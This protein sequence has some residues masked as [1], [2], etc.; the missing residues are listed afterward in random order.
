[1][2]LL[3]DLEAM[4]FDASD[5]L[6]RCRN[7]NVE[8]QQTRQ[9]EMEALLRMQDS[10]HLPTVTFL[11]V[12]MATPWVGMESTRPPTLTSQ[13]VVADALESNHY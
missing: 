9:M 5:L 10:Q 2:D 7:T 12:E 3:G 1:M 8:M 6:G 11:L 13:V 4:R